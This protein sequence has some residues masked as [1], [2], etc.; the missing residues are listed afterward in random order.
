MPAPP[1]ILPASAPLIPSEPGR[2]DRVLTEEALKVHDQRFHQVNRP[3]LNKQIVQEPLQTYQR[4]P[5]SSSEH[6][7]V[8]PKPDAGIIFS[9][10]KTT[11]TKLLISDLDQFSSK[12]DSFDTLTNTD[13]YTD[14]SPKFTTDGS[15]TPTNLPHQAAE[16]PIDENGS[17]LTVRDIIGPFAKRMSISPS[18]LEAMRMSASNVYPT[19]HVAF[20]QNTAVESEGRSRID[21]TGSIVS[22]FSVND[23][24]NKYNSTNQLSTLPSRDSEATASESKH[25]ELPQKDFNKV[26]EAYREFQKV[27]ESCLSPS[28]ISSYSFTTSCL[29]VTSSDENAFRDGLASLDANITRIQQSLKNAAN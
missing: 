27:P 1:T 6:P 28:D 10:S 11:P 12:N 17:S 2:Q 9:E 24:F 25:S 22:R 8:I 4:T 3:D 19:K 15:S 18:R 14:S 16:T 23:Y 7:V 20:D 29:T 26:L 5:P 13:T 21:D